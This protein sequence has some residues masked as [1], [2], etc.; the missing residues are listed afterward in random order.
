MKFITFDLYSWRKP[1]ALDQTNDVLWRMKS[2]LFTEP[3]TIKVVYC[4]PRRNL[5][6]LTAMKIDFF[7]NR[8]IDSKNAHYTFSQKFDYLFDASDFSIT[9]DI[10]L[11]L[12]KSF[13]VLAD[14]MM[15]CKSGCKSIT[16]P[17]VRP[18]VSL[19]SM[20]TLLRTFVLYITIELSCA[21]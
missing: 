14:I 6:L 19:L 8:R 10:F 5:L 3:F 13:N 12:L 7:F 21:D 1:Q 4:S 2:K 9:S 18:Y 15:H 11:F 16:S 20:K 17:E